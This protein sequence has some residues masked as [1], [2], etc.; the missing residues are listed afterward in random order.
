MAKIMTVLEG[1]LK[2]G[3]S[4]LGGKNNSKIKLVYTTKVSLNFICF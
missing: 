1:L 2:L 3:M 4:L